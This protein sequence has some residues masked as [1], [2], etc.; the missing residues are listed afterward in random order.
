MKILIISLWYYPEPVG[1]PHDLAVELV[2]RGHQVTVI[3]GFPNYPSGQI[4]PGYRSQLLRWETIDGVRVLRVAHM[5]DRSRSAVRRILSY[6]SFSFIATVLGVL[7]LEQP[8]VIWTYQIGL[9]GIAIGALKS[10]PLI[11]EVQ[12][13]WPDW[14]RS[15]TNGISGWLNRILMAQEKLIYRRAAAVTTITDGFRSILLT[16]GITA[17]KIEVIPNW[18]ND[19]HFRPVDRD[20]ALGIREGLVDRFNVIYGGNIG[21]AQGLDV[22]L[23]AADLL[24]EVQNIQFTIIG[25]GVERNE[26]VERARSKDLKNVRFIGSRSPDQMAQ[27]FA[28]ADVLLLHL[29]QDPAY[30]ITIPSKTYA[31]LASGRPILAAAQGDVADLIEKIGAGVVCASQDPQA[32]ADVVRYFLSIS[33]DEREAIGQAGRNAFLANFTRSQLVTRYEMIANRVRGLAI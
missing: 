23:E 4:Y 12:D 27:Y 5:V 26:L 8:E 18:A 19:E 17:D 32:L 6:M 20:M 10:A 31:Y 1:K 15:A 22:V 9:P 28:F 25:D 21:A 29:V 7:L 14:G 30:E 3:T 24:Q 2:K 11:H 33:R 13:L 16:R